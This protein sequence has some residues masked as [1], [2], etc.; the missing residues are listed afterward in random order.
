MANKNP[1][2]NL[3]KWLHPQKEQTTAKPIPHQ[4]TKTH[5]AKGAAH[6]AGK[7]SSKR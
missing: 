3:G 2:A 1:H 4:T 6:G 5:M 7:G